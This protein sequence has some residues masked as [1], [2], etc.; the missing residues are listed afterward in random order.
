M[1]K[2]IEHE[3]KWTETNCNWTS[4]WKN[5]WVNESK[6]VNDSKQS[7]KGRVGKRWVNEL[8]LKWNEL[9]WIVIERVNWKSKRVKYSKES[10]KGLALFIYLFLLALFLIKTSWYIYWDGAIE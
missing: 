3:M 1:S 4:T 10:D 2:W 9:K 8:N 7:G 6:R 5:K